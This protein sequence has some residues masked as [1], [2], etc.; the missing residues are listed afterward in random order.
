MTDDIGT[1][2][3]AIYLKYNTTVTYH[4]KYYS[5][6]SEKVF[7]KLLLKTCNITYNIYVLYI[8]YIKHIN[9]YL[10]IYTTQHYFKSYH[11]SYTKL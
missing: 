2:I 8:L 1:S 6:K 4:K 5:Y 7:I 11:D 3:L 9:I 10:I